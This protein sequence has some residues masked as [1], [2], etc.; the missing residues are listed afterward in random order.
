MVLQSLHEF[1]R[2][3]PCLVTLLIF[4]SR[5][6]LMMNVE[7]T[8]TLLLPILFGVVVGCGSGDDNNTATGEEDIAITPS[9]EQSVAQ[10]ESVDYTFSGLNDSQAYR[11][12]LVVEDNVTV[13]S[14]AGVF[15][16]GD[17]NGAA[18]AG[19]S[20][21][22]ALIVSV[23]GEARTGAKTVPGG[24]D[25]PASP[26]GVFP[27]GGEIKL[28]LQGVAAGSVYPV[29]Y[30]NGGASTFLEIGDDGVPSEVHYIG[31][32]LTVT[33]GGEAPSVMPATSQTIAVGAKTSYTVSGLSD[34]QAYRI[35]LVVKDNATVTSGAGVFMDGDGNGAAD[36]GASENTALIVSVNG[37]ARTGAKTVPGGDDDPASPSGVFPSG[38]ELSFEVEGVAAGS[39]YPVIYHN[40]GASTFL[41]IDDNGAPKEVHIVAPEVVVQ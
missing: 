38:G 13:A 37:E 24:D 17:A 22:T 26:S 21:N 30:H 8:R 11:I 25:D 14:G 40:G 3:V 35:T 39:V 41:E 9:A 23:N 5:R 28:S 27:S 20:E 31:S 6:L 34:T 2:V 4:K 10:G 15:V 7:S 18:D 32:K 36:A 12:T 29:L 1:Y 19:A 33:G 16:D